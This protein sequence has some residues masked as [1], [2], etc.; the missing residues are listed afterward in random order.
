LA[1]GGLFLRRI[2]ARVSEVPSGFSWF[3]KGKVAASGFP[4]SKRQFRWLSLQGIKAIITL[5]EYPLSEDAAHYFELIHIPMQDHLP[6]SPEKLLYAASQIQKKV[7]E[8]KP[9]LVHCLAG[10]GRT[11][12][13][14]AAWLI[15]NGVN[16]SEAIARVRELRPGSIENG[17]ESSLYQLQSI[18]RSSNNTRSSV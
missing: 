5:T 1:K 9:V 13:V 10:Q 7:E 15:Q 3:V 12:C 4:A 11:G 2:R 18:V 17:Q 8:G 16:V 6:P 14:L